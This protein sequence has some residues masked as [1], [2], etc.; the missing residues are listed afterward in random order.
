M[1]RSRWERGRAGRRGYALDLTAWLPRKDDGYRLPLSL[2]PLDP[3]CGENL[4]NSW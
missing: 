3:R 1:M 4:I 2:R